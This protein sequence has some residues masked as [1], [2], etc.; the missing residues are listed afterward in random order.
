MHYA[1]VRCNPLARHASTLCTAD[2]ARGGGRRRGEEEGEEDGEDG[3]CNWAER[4]ED[5]T[6]TI[7]TRIVG[8]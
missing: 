1:P 3:E 5:V 8:N 7:K 4:G 6:L 2:D